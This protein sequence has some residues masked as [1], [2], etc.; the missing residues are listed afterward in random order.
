MCKACNHEGRRF[1]CVIGSHA[2]FECVACG[3]WFSI[4]GKDGEKECGSMDSQ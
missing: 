1:V 3:R 2:Y 4:C